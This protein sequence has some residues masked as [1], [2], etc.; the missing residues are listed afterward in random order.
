MSQ[1]WVQ[2]SVP[3]DTAISI[4]DRADRIVA[5]CVN[6]RKW[7]S[8]TRDELRAALMNLLAPF[9]HGVRVYVYFADERVNVHV[10]E[11]QKITDAELEILHAERRDTSGDH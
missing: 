10:F 7:T 5:A 1:P 6:G 3:E 11:G 2:I 8:R 4:E 9:M